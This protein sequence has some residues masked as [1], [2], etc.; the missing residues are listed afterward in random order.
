MCALASGSRTNV[1]AMRRWF[2][3][4]SRFVVRLCFHPRF[5]CL[6]RAIAPGLAMHFGM[7]FGADRDQVLFCVMARTPAGLLVMNLYVLHS[8]ADL[9]APAVT[10]ENLAPQLAVALW[11]H[12]KARLLAVN[13]LHAY[14]P[15]NW[16]RKASCRAL[17]RNR[18]LREI[19]SSRMSGLPPSRLA[20]ARKFAQ[21]ISSSR[22]GTCPTR[23]SRLQTG[24]PLGKRT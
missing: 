14:F 18:K 13:R 12:S 21:I 10:L 3:F 5:L 6:N 4:G 19:D 7:A 24:S 23:A 16:D 1:Q 17:G 2:G 22:P 9:T 11:I 8:A 20:A 15:T